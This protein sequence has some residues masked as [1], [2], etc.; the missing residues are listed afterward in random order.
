M[1]QPFKRLYPYLWRYWPA[2][3]GGFVCLLLSNYLDIRVA[4]LLGAGIDVLE[5]N[6]G[7]LS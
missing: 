3:A 4:V 5:F 2:L 7:P 6:L 1:N